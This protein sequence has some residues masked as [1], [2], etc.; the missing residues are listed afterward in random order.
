MNTTRRTTMALAAGVVVLA[1][2]VAGCISPRPQIAEPAGSLQ[3][4]ADASA[5]VQGLNERID[6]AGQQNTQP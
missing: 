3:P 5:A 6:D 4:A 1:A 2:A